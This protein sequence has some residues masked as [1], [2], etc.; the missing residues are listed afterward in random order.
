MSRSAIVGQSGSRG[1]GLLSTPEPPKHWRKHEHSLPRKHRR[2]LIRRSPTYCSSKPNTTLGHLSNAA[3]AN[4]CSRVAAGVRA[5]DISLSL[6]AR[7]LAL[8]ARLVGAYE[9]ATWPHLLDEG[10]QLL[11]EAECAS[12]PAV[13]VGACVAAADLT[14]LIAESEF[15][16]Q[17]LHLRVIESFGAMLPLPKRV[18]LADYF[19]RRFREVTDL[20][21]KALRLAEDAASPPDTARVQ[22]A[23]ARFMVMHCALAVIQSG[24][25]RESTR[26]Q[27]ETAVQLGLRAAQTYSELGVPRSVV[28]A[29]NAAAEAASVLGDRNR[30]TKLTKEASRIA[31]FYGYDDLRATAQ[32][33]AEGPTAPDRH[34]QAQDPPPFNHL[35]PQERVEFVEQLLRA[36]HVAPSDAELARPVLRDELADLAVHGATCEETCRHLALLRDLSGPRIGPFFAELRWSLS[37][38]MRGISS[39]SRNA[40]AK[41]LLRRFTEDFC[42]SCELRSPGQPSDGLD[43]VDQ[44]YAPLFERLYRSGSGTASS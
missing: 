9:P 39:I 3:M 27:A 5:E 2:T 29:L 19:V 10:R 24:D 12:A 32:R 20:Y 37:C 4:E 43:A 14:N 7:L 38:R 6:N 18:E 40:R 44:I 17:T 8:N 42:S 25:D 34:R 1:C 22:I 15:R 26:E 33:I 35:N 13:A 28:I 36:S 16:S 31:G 11:A 21:E 30:I 41:P 23:L